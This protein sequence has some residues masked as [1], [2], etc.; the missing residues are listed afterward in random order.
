MIV[1]NPINAIV[2][3]AA[4]V[5]KK[6]GGFDARRLFGITT[7]DV[8]RAETFLAEMLDKR[9]ELGTGAVVDVIGGHSAET[10]I[11]LFSQVEEAKTLTSVQVDNLIY[12]E[13]NQLNVYFLEV[14][15]C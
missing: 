5:L 7:L 11:P 14:W 4:E 15:N 12:R 6:N 3:F 2:P 1:S 13:W 8:V 10:M 9:T